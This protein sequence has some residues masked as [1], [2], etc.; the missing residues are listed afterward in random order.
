MRIGITLQS[1]RHFGGIGTYTQQIMKHLLTIDEKNDYILIY[2]SFGQAHKSLGQFANHSN[3]TE[4]LSNSLVPHAVYWDHLVVPQ[5]ARKH[6]VDLLFNPYLSVPLRGHFRKVLVMH[7]SEWFTMPEVFWFTERLTGSL[8]MKAFMAAADKIIS[9]SN[10]VT[11]DCIRATGLPKSKFKTI[12]HGLGDGFKPIADKTV[13]RHAKEKYRLPDRFVLFVGGIY[14]QKNLSVL[15][16]AFA[17]LAHDIPHQLVI[18][19]NTRWKH[20]GDLKLIK[21]KGLENKV[22]L[23]GWVTPED[24]PALYNLAE[25]FVYP[26]LYEGFGLCLVEA[27]ACGCPTV[28]A[29]TGA[30]PEV[31][32]D[33]ALLVDPRNPV[34]MKDAIL[35][36]VSDSATSSQLVQK[37]LIRAREFTWERCAGQTLEAFSEVQ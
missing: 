21:E 6:C 32:Q 20:S 31:A 18:A 26:S 8:R 4:V 36:L 15:L 3:V 13:L 27:M 23:L 30:L 1:L 19:G 11:E 37:G 7:N 17:L 5:V 12:Y 10:A 2:P 16:R 24:L 33:A 35:K 25:C 22:Q 28:A 9:V 29:S 34:E 14:P